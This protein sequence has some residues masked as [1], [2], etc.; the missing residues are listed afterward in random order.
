MVASPDHQVDGDGD[1][2]MRRGKIIFKYVKMLL[3]RK[4]WDSAQIMVID[5]SVYVGATASGLAA[6]YLNRNEYIKVRGCHQMEP[7]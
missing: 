7:Q 1:T 3:A 4:Q 6:A 2:S 5:F